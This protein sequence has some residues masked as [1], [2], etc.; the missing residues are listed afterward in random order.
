M[1]GD[2]T[3]SSTTIAI[4]RNITGFLRYP[5]HSA[6]VRTPQ[7][8]IPV[9][10]VRTFAGERIIQYHAKGLRRWFT[11]EASEHIEVLRDGIVI[12]A[13]PSAWLAL[14]SVLPA[15]PDEQKSS[16]ADLFAEGQK[17][18]KERQK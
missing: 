9:D 13:Y 11:L 3:C 1:A 18:L 2:F 14:E 7:G 8:D 6:T 17:I 12:A 15:K 10:K 4:V 16:A 5:C